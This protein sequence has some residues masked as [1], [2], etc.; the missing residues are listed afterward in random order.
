MHNIH[1]F[2]SKHSANTLLATFSFLLGGESPQMTA[3]MRLKV[4]WYK[5]TMRD[6]SHCIRELTCCPGGECKWVTG[7]LADAGGKGPRAMLSES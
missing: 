1:V 3:C 2:H 6:M 5:M 4:R 7:W